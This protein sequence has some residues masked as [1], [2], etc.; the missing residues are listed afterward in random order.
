MIMKGRDLEEQYCYNK[1]SGSVEPAALLYHKDRLHLGTDARMASDFL[2]L[3]Q[4][5][6][7]F[8]SSSAPR[9]SL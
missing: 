4:M 5:Q 6:G 3:L 1:G 9:Q 8:P 2:L 7:L